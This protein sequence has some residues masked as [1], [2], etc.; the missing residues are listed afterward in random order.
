MEVTVSQFR[1]FGEAALRR[2]ACKASP[3]AAARAHAATP[4]FVVVE[5]RIPHVTAIALAILAGSSLAGLGGLAY[6]S[7]RRDHEDPPTV[8]DCGT[9]GPARAR[10]DVRGQ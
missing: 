3:F 7:R 5:C 10:R 2:T 9:P 6:V 1:Q 8:L 4:T